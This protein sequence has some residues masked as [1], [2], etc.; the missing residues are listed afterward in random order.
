MR[1][2]SHSER[3]LPREDNYEVLLHS[4]SDPP[5]SCPHLCLQLFIPH[6]GKIQLR[7]GDEP[8]EVPLDTSFVW[9]DPLSNEGATSSVSIGMAPTGEY[10]QILRTCSV[11][12]SLRPEQE[13]SFMYDACLSALAQMAPKPS[14]YY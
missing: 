6:K 10:T 8:A 4:G 5:S 2:V 14:L 1:G 9:T 3:P 11:T 12:T 7:L 13:Q